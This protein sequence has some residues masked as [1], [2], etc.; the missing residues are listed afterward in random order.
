MALIIGRITGTV[1][2]GIE[3]GEAIGTVAG[4][5]DGTGGTKKSGNIPTP[6]KCDERRTRNTFDWAV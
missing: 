6:G 4:T 1:I 3:A 5:E 2:G